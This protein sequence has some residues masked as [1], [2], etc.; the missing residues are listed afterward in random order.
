MALDTYCT[1]RMLPV[2]FFIHCCLALA[3]SLSETPDPG[4]NIVFVLADDLGYAELGCFGSESIRTP[5]LDRLA[6]EGMRFTRHYA[7]DA[8][9]APSRCVLLTGLHTG[10]AHV[11]D[12]SGSHRKKNPH[13]EG[14]V[15]LPAG[16]PTLA[17]LL[18]QQGYATGAF[19]KWGLGGPEESGEPHLQGF[20]E[21]FGY[22]CQA[23]AHNHYPDH[24]WH[25][26]ER[27]E[28]GNRVFSAHQKIKSAPAS[29]EGWD[30]FQ[31]QTYAPDLFIE[32]AEDFIRANA[33]QPFFLYYPSAIPHVAL[34]VPDEDLEAYPT[35]WDEQP[36][37]GNK[38]YLPHPRPRAAYAAMI[39]HL[40]AE[41]GR[42][43]KVIAEEG[44]SDNTLF[45]FTS[46]N[47]PSYAGGSDS[48]F[49]GSAGQL[50][51]LKGSLYEGGLRVPLIA[52][53]P[54]TVPAGTASERVCAFQDFLPTLCSL[55]GADYPEGLDG[56]D[57]SG[58]LR[59]FASRRAQRPPLYWELGRR[60]ALLHG[61][62]KWVRQTSKKG[63][64]TE[65][66]FDLESDPSE[67]TNLALKHP[68]QLVAMR[69]L[70]SSQ[71]TP[72][73]LFPSPFDEEAPSDDD[74]D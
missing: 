43:M 8:V 17:R 14:Q 23:Q 36:Y 52:H 65:E 54:G 48:K 19:G 60:Q 24:L 42:L 45:I 47:G 12:N 7:G 49:F 15:P 13:G 57:L 66:L 64:V 51:G 30:R 27:V 40:D 71:R 11:R 20:D 70:A 16:T 22:L 34:Q 53:W 56:V 5:H 28:A 73:G 44:L 3:G 1:G 74:S 68:K 58:T 41:V 63:V 29:A 67:S 61:R 18:Q 32:R 10:H 26:G 33:D 6:R 35:T 59:G 69:T 38:G 72:S 9:C 39:T 62:W 50:R 25:N 46:D 21:F 4:P 55:A 37:L 2:Q 31:G